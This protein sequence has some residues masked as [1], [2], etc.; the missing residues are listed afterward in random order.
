MTPSEH[1]FQFPADIISK[2][3]KYKQVFLKRCD[4]RIQMF[5][6]IIVQGDSRKGFYAL[7]GDDLSMFRIKEFGSGGR[8]GCRALSSHYKCIEITEG[9]PVMLDTSPDGI[10][11]HIGVQGHT[12]CQG[13]C[14]E[15][16]PMSSNLLPGEALHATYRD[17][18]GD[19]G[20][21][22]DNGDNGD[23]GD[24]GKQGDLVDIALTTIALLSG[25]V[26]I[27]S[28]VALVRK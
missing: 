25:I 7:D 13:D 2:S 17:D 11:P 23:N 18:N 28:I 10:C 22:G 5:G 8:M 19:N 6:C 9:T 4:G 15:F 12:A 14:M 24:K 26:F 1:V 21:K 16:P 20:D 27:V 3:R